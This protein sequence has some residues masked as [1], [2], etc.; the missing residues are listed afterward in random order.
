MYSEGFRALKGYIG[1]RQ[2]FYRDYLL[3]PQSIDEETTLGPIKNIPY[4]YMDPLGLGC[5]NE[6]NVWGKFTTTAAVDSTVA[7]P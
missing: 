4:T 1:F 5:K 7:W 2:G 3:G 6:C